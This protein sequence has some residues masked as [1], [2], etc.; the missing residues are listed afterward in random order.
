MLPNSSGRMHLSFVFTLN[1]VFTEGSTCAAELQASS[2]HVHVM[3]SASFSWFYISTSSAHPDKPEQICADSTALSVW[4][5][6][7]WTVSPPNIL[8]QIW[9]TVSSSNTQT[10]SVSFDLLSLFLQVCVSLPSSPW[11]PKQV[12]YW[13][14]FLVCPCFSCFIEILTIVD[15]ACDWFKYLPLYLPCFL[16][17]P[18]CHHLC[19]VSW[20]SD[21]CCL[22]SS[23]LEMRRGYADFM[24]TA[25]LGDASLFQ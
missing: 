20:F 18:N 17:L 21:R 22:M 8:S 16:F 24:G 19:F 4:M 25:G 15:N 3:W 10:S 9:S 6:S 12:S 1:L 2:E 11:S 13:I 7:S 23:W 14:N 5:T